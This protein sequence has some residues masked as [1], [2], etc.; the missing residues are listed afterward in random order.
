M[1]RQMTPFDIDGLTHRR[2]IQFLGQVVVVKH[3]RAPIGRCG[4]EQKVVGRKVLFG[5]GTTDATEN[6]ASGRDLEVPNIG[7]ERLG[8]RDARLLRYQRNVM[9]PESSPESA[10]R[11]VDE[12]E[13]ALIVNRGPNHPAIVGESPRARS[14]RSENHSARRLIEVAQREDQ[15]D[16]E[17]EKTIDERRPPREGLVYP[18]KVAENKS[19]E[20]DEDDMSPDE[21]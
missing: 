5:R 14:V 21:Q 19:D 18:L 9:T 6:P 7:D 2:P 11:R 8:L 4:D 10:P 13:S 3:G 20:R 12:N 17:E 1:Y 15:E 16:G